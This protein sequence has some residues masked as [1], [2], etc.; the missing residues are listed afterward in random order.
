[1]KKHKKEVPSWNI[2]VTELKK[3]ERNQ[4]VFMLS[5]N[6][7]QLVIIDLQDPIGVLLQKPFR[8]EKNEGVITAVFCLN[9]WIF[10]GRTKKQKEF[11]KPFFIVGSYLRE[12][13]C[14][15]YKAEGTDLP[16]IL[17]NPYIRYVNHDERKAIAEKLGLTHASV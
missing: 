2:S 12:N 17:G 8:I 3:W 13:K 1:M 15:I 14:F 9:S 16:M 4:G 6:L 10:E 7:C 5:G 11:L